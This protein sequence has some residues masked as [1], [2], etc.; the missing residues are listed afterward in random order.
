M[1]ENNKSEYV[2]KYDEYNMQPVTGSAPYRFVRNPANPN[3]IIAVTGDFIWTVKD[4]KVIKFPVDQCE[5]YK[6]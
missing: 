4:G 2:W 5:E 1:D 3:H 6:P